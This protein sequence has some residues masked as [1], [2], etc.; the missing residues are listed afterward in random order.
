MLA[1]QAKIVT[2]RELRR[3]FDHVMHGRHLERDRVIV[4][5]SF[6]AGLRAV[7]ISGLTWSMVTNSDGTLSDTIAL[8]NRA[9]KGKSGGRHIPMHPELREAL[10]ALR[11]ARPDKVRPNWPVI[12]SERARGLSPNALAHWFHDVFRAVGIEGASSHSGRRTFITQAARQIVAAGGT[13]RDVQE[14]AGHASLDM[15][16]R[17]IQADAA[18]KRKVVAML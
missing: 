9:S 14:L 7:E 3:V 18:A 5:L 17:Y 2:P 10:L 15:T 8:P 4:L 12:Y 11:E 6:K 16:A 13:L 1:K